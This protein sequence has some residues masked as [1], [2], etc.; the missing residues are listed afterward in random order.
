MST[1]KRAKRIRTV[2]SETIL[3]RI[4]DPDG[5]HPIFSGEGAS[6]SA[7][8][9]HEAGQKV[10]YTS[11]NYS[12]ALLEVL[13]HSSS[14]MPPN[15][16]FIR[17]TAPANA[18]YEVVSKDSLEGWAQ[19]DAIASR[20]FGAKWVADGRSLLLFVPSVVAREEQNVVINAN[21]RDFASVKASLETPV[22]WDE[23][24][25]D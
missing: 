17:I 18:S 12:T 21:H 5:E 14:Q 4:G 22:W 11:L 10:L 1:A 8:R 23:R 25:F 7:G 9:W 13:A 2:G 24:L 6:R 19:R 20:A 16:H 3:F 15:Q